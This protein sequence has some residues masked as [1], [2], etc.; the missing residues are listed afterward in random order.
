MSTQLATETL[1]TREQ[2]LE[3]AVQA[4]GRLL[5]ATDQYGFTTK[6]SEEFWEAQADTAMENGQASDDIRREVWEQ[7]RQAYN[8]AQHQCPMR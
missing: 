4:L 7:A 3:T 1:V 6:R 5:C 8:D 2:A